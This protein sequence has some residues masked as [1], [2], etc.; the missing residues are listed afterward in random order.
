VNVIG[1]DDG[2]V[3]FRGRSVVKVDVV[4]VVD[5]EV[6]FGVLFVVRGRVVVKGVSRRNG[7]TFSAL[8]SQNCLGYESTIVGC[9]RGPR[10]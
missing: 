4:F 8:R 7:L 9:S 2:F 5:V 1:R 6:V 3:P 10:G